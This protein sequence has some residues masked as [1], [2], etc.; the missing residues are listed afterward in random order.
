MATPKHNKNSPQFRLRDSSNLLRN[1]YPKR[2]LL[3]ATEINASLVPRELEEM[4]QQESCVAPPKWVAPFAVLIV[5]RCSHLKVGIWKLRSMYA[6]Y[7]NY[8]EA[9]LLIALFAFG[10]LSV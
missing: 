8:S 1:V 4:T 9:L 2:Y 6:K 10:K 7:K 5:W 3:F